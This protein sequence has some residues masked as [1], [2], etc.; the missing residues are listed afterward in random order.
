MRG[1]ALV[2]LL[3]TG[4]DLHH[5]SFEAATDS[6][7]HP[8]PCCHREAQAT[9]RQSGTRHALI[10]F[11]SSPTDVLNSLC[12]G[13]G[14]RGAA[15][16]CRGG[17]S[18]LACLKVSQKIMLPNPNQCSTFSSEMEPCSPQQ[19]S[20]VPHTRELLVALPAQEGFLRCCRISWSRAHYRDHRRWEWGA[21]TW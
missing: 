5:P 15:C 8:V 14:L 20:L 7:P 16:I 19:G 11:F 4:A 6:C 17:D 21:G 10:F 2:S 18:C 9:V 3:G 13:K 1:K 12:L